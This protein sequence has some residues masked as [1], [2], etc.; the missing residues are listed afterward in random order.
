MQSDGTR[1]LSAYVCS[2]ARYK[3]KIMSS[4][5]ESVCFGAFAM[6][7]Y[8]CSVLEGPFRAVQVPK[9]LFRWGVCGDN[10]CHRTSRALSSQVIAGW[11][12]N[13][14][15]RCNSLPIR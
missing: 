3:L 6:P 12:M 8:P 10:L 9:L 11:V 15:L 13:P 7:G 5:E 4:S 14:E 2:D 1:H